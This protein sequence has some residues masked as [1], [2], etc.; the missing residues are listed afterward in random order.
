MQVCV[1]FC[2]HFSIAY[3]LISKVYQLKD[4]SLTIIS[5]CVIEIFYYSHSGKT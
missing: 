5:Y 2:Q 1:V 4:T 3:N